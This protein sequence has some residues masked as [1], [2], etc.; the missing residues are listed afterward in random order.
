MKKQLLI[1]LTVTT[2]CFSAHASERVARFILQI[3]GTV[4]LELLRR[5]HQQPPT[6]QSWNDYQRT[7]HR[8][9]SGK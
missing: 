6:L 1:L 2:L 5:L 8:D 4:V 3:K 7:V 9:F